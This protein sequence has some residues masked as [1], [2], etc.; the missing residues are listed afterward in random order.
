MFS[1]RADR[2]GTSYLS[3]TIDS[4][5]LEEPAGENQKEGA[6]QGVHATLMKGATFVTKSLST[7]VHIPQILTGALDSL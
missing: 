2:H 6:T 3:G 1:V 5:K 7:S 4:G